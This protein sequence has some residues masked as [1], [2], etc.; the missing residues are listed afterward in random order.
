VTS[1][2]ALRGS[3]VGAGRAGEPERGEPAPRIWV[4][5]WCA[6]RHVTRP[7]FSADADV[8]G[9][10]EC[11]RCGN[12]AGQDRENP[13]PRLLTGPSKTHMDYLRE[14]RSASEGEAILAEALSRLRAAPTR[15]H[16]T[17]PLQADGRPRESARA[18]KRVSHAGEEVD[19]TVQGSPPAAPQGRPTRRKPAGARGTA[20]AASTKQ[21]R[22]P[23]TEPLRGSEPLRTPAGTLAD[24]T[25]V[26]PSETWCGKCTYKKTSPSHRGICLG[27]W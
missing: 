2:S 21:T 16:V 3:R 18:L 9:T 8:P 13:P 17:V 24:S 12:P 14:R 15:S 10:W 7:G 27:E 11:A 1:G 19:R 25:P 20:R 22:P 6:D 26:E 4:S 23:A 5:F